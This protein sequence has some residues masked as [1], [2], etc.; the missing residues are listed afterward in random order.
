MKIF[1][2]EN[3]PARTVREL[4]KLGHDV[5]DIRGTD[6]EGVTDEE[7]WGLVQKEGRLLITTDK[8]FAQ[9][10]YEKHYGILVVKLKQPNRIKIHQKVMHAMGL[11][12]EKE[13]LGTTLV[14]QDI[15]HSVWK[16]KKKSK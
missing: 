12:K 16:A 6:K 9:K 7:V 3:I 2:D 1:V 13:W 15:F 8:G 11:F 10:R 4:C 5:M 14:M